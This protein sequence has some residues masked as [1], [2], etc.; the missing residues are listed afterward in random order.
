MPEQKPSI[1]Y[2]YQ[3]RCLDCENFEDNLPVNPYSA[4]AKQAAIANGWAPAKVNTYTVPVWAFADKCTNCAPD[5]SVFGGDEACPPE[6][7]FLAKGGQHSG[8]VCF[9]TTTA[10]IFAGNWCLLPDY[11]DSPRAADLKKQM[12]VTSGNVEVKNGECV[13]PMPPTFH[14]DHTSGEALCLR[15]LTASLTDKRRV[16]FWF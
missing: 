6:Y 2:Q 5:G 10:R 1:P 11:K 15:G 9:K 8:M 4:E 14:S 16:R 3:D 7:P 13:Q 12:V